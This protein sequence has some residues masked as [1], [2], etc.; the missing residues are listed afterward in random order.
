[1]LSVP[2]IA[3]MLKIKAFKETDPRG[4]ADLLKEDRDEVCDFYLS[5]AQKC[6]GLMVTNTYDLFLEEQ[7][8]GFFTLSNYLLELDRDRRRDQLMEKKHL[9]CTPPAALLGRLYILKKYRRKG[10]GAEAMWQ[11]IRICLNSKTACRF[12]VLH[13]ERE[14]EHLFDAYSSLGWIRVSGMSTMFFDLLRYKLHARRL[15]KLASLPPKEELKAFA[16]LQKQ[17]RQ[18]Q[19]L[20]LQF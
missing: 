15:K 3:N 12:L 11:A 6:E 5:E 1:M 14:K 10:H 9:P 19:R 4:I 17:E 7:F 8:C 2:A 18:Q 13:V 20:N 16:E